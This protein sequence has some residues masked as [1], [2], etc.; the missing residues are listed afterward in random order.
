MKTTR[1]ES[2]D[3]GTAVLDAPPRSA[4]PEYKLIDVDKLLRLFWKRRLIVIAFAVAGTLGGV[5]ASQVVK[6]QFDATVRMMPPDRKDSSLISFSSRNDGD[7]YLSLIQ[8]RT[9]ADDIIERQH[10][11]DYFHTTK[12]SALRARLAGLSKI[13]VDKDQFITV[14]VRAQ[15]AETAVRIANEY[16]AALSRLN[17]DLAQFQARSREEFYQVPLEDEKNKLA[18]AEDDL[19]LAEQKTGMV[20]P[21][22]QVQLGLSA[23]SSLEQQIRAR[24]EQLAALQTS[25]TDQNPQVV[26]LK[27]QIAS[28]TGQLG[29]LQAQTG[30]TGSRPAAARLPT[31]TLEVERLAREVKF[32]ET[33]FQI[34]SRQYENARIDDSYSPPV[35]LVD[36]AVMPDEKSWPPRKLFIA[37]GLLVGILLGLGYVWIRR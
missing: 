5:L 2:S 9:V 11:A 27:S 6:P 4:D 32:H 10:L 7:L 14:R 17:R 3:L 28:L 13:S 33:L 16:P 24:N 22:S 26:Q 15:E 18:A 12:P 36:K 21:E 29:L 30:G 35:E 34:L 37:I 1:N 23:I 20:A 25:S 19:K 31:L 8:S